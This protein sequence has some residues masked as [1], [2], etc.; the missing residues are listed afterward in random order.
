MTN[1]KRNILTIKQIE[2]E[3]GRAKDSSGPLYTF[4]NGELICWG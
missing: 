3:L 4:S 1:I 2:R